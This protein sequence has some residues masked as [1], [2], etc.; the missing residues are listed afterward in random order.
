MSAPPADLWGRA[1]KALATAR[2]VLSMDPD[3]AGSRAYYAAFY[4]ASARFALDGR[5]FS[6]HSAVHAA[7]HRDLVHLGGWPS[8]LGTVT[9]RFPSPHRMNTHH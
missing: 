3:A 9:I 1:R 7:V 4:A 2:H 6:K 5:Q 8:E